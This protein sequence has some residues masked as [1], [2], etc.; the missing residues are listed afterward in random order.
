MIAISKSRKLDKRTWE[1]SAH[2]NGTDEGDLTAYAY[3]REGKKLKSKQ[4]SAT[5]SDD[6]PSE[7]IEASCK[8]RQRVVSGGFSSTGDNEQSI[9]RVPTSM[10]QGRRTWSLTAFQSGTGRPRRRHRLRLL[11]EEE[12]QELVSRHRR[13]GPD[14]RYARA[15]PVAQLVRAA[16]S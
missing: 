10:K 1:V 15:G 6:N 9:A 7:Q 16:D 2:V 11:R 12:A 4:S 13:I 3:C 5:V 14:A 8:R